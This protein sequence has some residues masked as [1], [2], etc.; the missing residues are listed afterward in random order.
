MFKILSN[1]KAYRILDRIASGSDVYILSP[2]YSLDSSMKMI[3]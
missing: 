3:I 1:N 2:T